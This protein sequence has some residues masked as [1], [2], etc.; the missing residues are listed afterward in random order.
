MI[1]NLTRRPGGASLSS[2]AHTMVSMANCA[3]IAGHQP[4][5]DWRM[6]PARVYQTRERRDNQWEW[7]FDQPVTNSP[8]DV[9]WVYEDATWRPAPSLCGVK[10]DERWELPWNAQ[11]PEAIARLR[12]IVPRFLRLNSVVR[13]RGDALFEK[14]KLDPANT[15][16]V[17]YRGTDKSQ[18]ATIYPPEAFFGTLDK[19][20]SQLWI[21]AE[22]DAAIAKFRSRYPDAV[23][24]S[25]FFVAPAGPVMADLAN[26]AGGYEKGLAAA[27]MLYL[28]SRCGTLVKN[29]A[30]IGDLAAGLSAGEVVCIT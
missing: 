24:M 27:T 25:E 30:N 13:Q 15:V 11:T 23:F 20:K 10:V 26:P 18:E 22:D 7:F 16:G 14:Y 3:T 6:S 29:A 2:Y 28:F 9:T 12:E 1:V 5:V 8:G 19:V 21:Q 17:S 4:Y